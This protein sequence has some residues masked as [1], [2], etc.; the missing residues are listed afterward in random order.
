MPS[1][2]FADAGFLQ[3]RVY[4][5]GDI[6]ATVVCLCST[7]VLAGW[8]LGIERLTSISRGWPYMARTTALCF[9]LSTI[10]R[11]C[12]AHLDARIAWPISRDRL[13]LAR[14]VLAALV[15]CQAVI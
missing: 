14:D 3:R 5:V 9:V 13:R 12:A 4:R 2:D 1:S 6:V 10:S 15:I 8:S 11:W 7:A